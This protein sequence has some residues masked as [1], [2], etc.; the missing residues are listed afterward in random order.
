M[1][2]VSL[3]KLG[4]RRL[5]P[6]LARAAQKVRRG[7]RSVYIAQDLVKMR[8]GLVTRMDARRL[9]GRLVRGPNTYIFASSVSPAASFCGF[10]VDAI[11]N[12]SNRFLRKVATVQICR[13]WDRIISL[14]RNRNISRKD[15]AVRV[16]YNTF[17]VPN[18]GFRL[19]RALGR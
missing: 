15:L 4:C 6:R 3:S 12:G 8:T 13:H 14:A 16:V 18:R 19:P 5:A 17:P 11:I 2:T 7:V 9:T 1:L 10:L